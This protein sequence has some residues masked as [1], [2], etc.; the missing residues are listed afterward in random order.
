[1]FCIT[2]SSGHRAKGVNRTIQRAVRF[3][4]KKTAPTITWRIRSFE[5]RW[6]RVGQ[7]PTAATGALHQQRLVRERAQPHAQLLAQDG[8]HLAWPAHREALL[9][10]PDLARRRQLA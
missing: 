1:M 7:P 2:W 6:E 4:E 8:P 10:Q 5:P 3:H 9:R